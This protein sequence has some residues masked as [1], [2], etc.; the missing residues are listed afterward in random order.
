MCVCINFHEHQYVW[1]CKW[2]I[3][4]EEN[5]LSWSKKWQWMCGVK[6]GKK[7]F[8][9]IR[10]KLDSFFGTFLWHFLVSCWV[11]SHIFLWS[12]W[13]L[14]CKCLCLFRSRFFFSA[15]SCHL[16]TLFHLLFDSVSMCCALKRLKRQ[17]KSY[18]VNEGKKKVSLNACF[19]VPLELLLG[20]WKRF[21]W[22]FCRV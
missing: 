18:K 5:F 3:K 1:I 11:I 17:K 15:V 16:L 8:M 13:R 19:N 2:H 20:S 6:K 21:C 22:H 7:A 14:P 4:E 12:L 10:E 9:K